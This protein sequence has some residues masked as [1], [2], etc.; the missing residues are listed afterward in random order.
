MKKKLLFVI[1]SLTSGGGERSLVNLLSHIEYDSYEVDLFLFS[2]EGL[3]MEYL[4][5]EVRVLPVPESYRLFANSIGKAVGQ[6]A[7]RLQFSLAFSRILYSLRHRF[8]GNTST[9]EQYNWKYLSRAVP[10]LSGKYDAAIGFLEKTSTYLV[11]D[12]VDA[13]KKVG[14]IHIDYDKM[15]MDPAFDRSY[16]DQLDRIVTVSEECAA[17]LHR[18]FPE[19]GHKVDVMY[20]IV[21]PKIIRGLADKT[22]TD[23]FDR[24][25]G[26]KVILSIGRLHPQKSF[27]IAIDACRRLIDRGY[28]VQWNIIG[29]GDEREKLTRLIQEKG[30][31]GKF[32]LLGLRANPYPYVRQ[33]DIYAQTSQFEGKSIAIDEAKI[34]A[35]PIVVTRFSTAQDQIEHGAEG[36]IMDMNGEDVAN[37]IERLLQD[38]K[39]RDRFS[40]RLSTLKLG[41]EDEI[42]KL[43][44]M[45]E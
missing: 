43:Y 40:E 35:K 13:Q 4:P 7:L 6:L 14:W 34:L 3:F 33:A 12:K 32:K 29:E 8:S 27:D 38:E 45:L 23:V 31:E 17:I 2:H 39:L 24:S 16:F 1:P 30:L 41:T 44:E 9:R 19:H 26:E 11:V 15:G 37:G 10:E 18:Q 28:N 20:N 22:S 21:S 5:P 42:D 25:E 36:L